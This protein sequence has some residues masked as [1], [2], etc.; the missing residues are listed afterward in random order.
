MILD[1][2]LSDFLGLFCWAVKAG[3][4]TEYFQINIEIK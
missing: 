1:F 4:S 2:Y 3:K